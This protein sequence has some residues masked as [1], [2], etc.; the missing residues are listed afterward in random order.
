MKE[1]GRD[2]RKNGLQAD[3]FQSKDGGNPAAKGWKCNRART[4]TAGA[5]SHRS[6]YQRKAELD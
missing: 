6:F 3:S 4:Q 1:N 2:R 5:V